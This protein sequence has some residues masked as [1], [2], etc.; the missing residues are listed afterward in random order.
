[1][2]DRTETRNIPSATRATLIPRETLTEEPQAVRLPTLLPLK[3]FITASLTVQ[4]TMRELVILIESGLVAP[5]GFGLG[6]DGAVLTEDEVF[7]ARTH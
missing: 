3:Y 5:R 4:L 7:E 6:E 2:N 1:M